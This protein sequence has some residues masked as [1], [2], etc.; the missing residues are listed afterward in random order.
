MIRRP[1]RSTLFPY[2][3]LFRSGFDLGALHYDEGRG[4]QFFRAVIERAKASPGVEDATVASNFPLGGGFLRT[5][6]PEGRDEASGYR[7]TLTGL[8][9]IAPNYFRALRI[10]LQSG[11][12][13]TDADRATTKKVVIANE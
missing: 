10:P 11:R 4:Q 6:F 7:G 8:N 9:D 1:P 13:F 12:E 2:T 5:V 3:T